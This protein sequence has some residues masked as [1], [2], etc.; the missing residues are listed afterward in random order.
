MS[1]E[2]TAKRK[3]TE[4]VVMVPFDKWLALTNAL[5]ATP[6]IAIA[7]LIKKAERIVSARKRNGRRIIELE[8]QLLKKCPDLDS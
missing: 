5:E 7:D 1:N 4:A 6:D 3:K 2:A 8:G